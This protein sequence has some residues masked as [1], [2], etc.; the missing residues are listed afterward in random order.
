MIGLLCFVL[1]VLA[2]PIKSKMRLEAE[3]AVLRHQLTVLR[4]RLQGRVRLTNKD[5]R[6]LIVLYRWFPS[7]LQVL[8]I[9]RPGRSSTGAALAFG[10]IGAG[11]HD[12]WEAGRRSRLGCVR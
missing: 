3:N 5:R 11:S 9:I 4:R 10:A 8:T 12:L 6:L 7:I 2:A 1:A